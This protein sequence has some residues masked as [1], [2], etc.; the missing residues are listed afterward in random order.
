MAAGDHDFQVGTGGQQIGEGGGRRDHVLKIVQDQQVPFCVQISADP[1]GSC[2]TGIIHLLQTQAGRDGWQDEVGI[3]DR[4]QGDKTGRLP[5]ILLQEGGSSH[6]QPRLAYAA[7][8][9]Q[10]HQAHFRMAQQLRQRDQLLFTTDEW[11]EKYR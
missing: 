2:A 9:R 1:L 5:E 11:S 4:Y 3:R 6:G 8:S 7:R 10:R